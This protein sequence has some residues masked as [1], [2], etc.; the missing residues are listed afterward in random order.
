MDAVEVELKFQVPAAKRAAVRKAVA[1]AGA[2]SVRLQAVYLDTADQRLA[3]AGL[4]LRLRKEGPRWVQT[5]KGRGDGLMQ[6]LEHEVALP[7]QRGRPQPD[8]ARHAGTAVGARLAALLADGT[9]LQERYGTDIQRLLRRVRTGG[10]TVE[11]AFDSGHI[12]AAGLRQ[13]VCEV[14]FELVAGPPQPLLALAARWVQRHGLWLDVRTKSERGHRLA[15]GVHEVPATGAAP[16]L[17][18]AAHTPGQALGA[19]LQAALAQ[20]LPN[21]AELGNGCGTPEHLHQLRVGLRRLRSALR[22]LAPWAGDADVA[23]ALEQAWRGPFRQLGALRDADVVAQ[24]LQQAGAVEGAPRH[25]VAAP[26]AAATAEADG[27]AAV[28]RHPEFSVLVLRSLRLALDASMLP[29][30]DHPSATPAGSPADAAARLLRPAW[31][32]ARRDGQ[33]FAA[34]SPEQRHRLRR[35]LKR[36]RYTL[37]FLQPLLRRK[38]A[39]RALEALRAALDALGAS[40]DALLA[41]AQLQ[42]AVAQGTADAATW[43]ALGWLAAQQDRLQR[44]AARQLARLP[45]AWPRAKSLSADR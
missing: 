4:A 42:A 3:A 9:P 12:T 38:S 39:A 8:P 28:V 24:L 27:A 34:A 35:Q 14:E 44:R 23:R 30:P 11:L 33:A 1:T 6:R 15:L 43:W 7:A 40:N 25:A 32:R 36:L 5:L 31:R 26:A 10:A 18:R 17:L 20:M 29:A 41:Q 16:V 21:A 19:V 22:L 2:R 45:A 13:P 37:E